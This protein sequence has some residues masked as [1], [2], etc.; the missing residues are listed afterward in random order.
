MERFLSKP[1]NDSLGLYMNSQSNQSAGLSNAR[2]KKRRSLVLPIL[3]VVTFVLI[4]A[5]IL[6]PHQM[7]SRV[8]RDEASAMYSLHALTNLELRYAAAHPSKGFTCDF[9]VLKTAVAPNG[10]H[11][12]EKFLL[13][14]SSEGYKF[15]LSGCEVDPKGVAVQYKAVAVPLLPGKTGFSAFCTDQTGE[16]RYGMNESPESCRP[17]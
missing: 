10:D 9:A 6:I 15:S 16:L 4:L 12:H 7:V 13:S 3:G 8:A 17:L 5:A 2:D 14:D 1:R 11:V